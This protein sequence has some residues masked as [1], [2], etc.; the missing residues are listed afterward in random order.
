MRVKIDI[1]DPIAIFTGLR[2]E[3]APL[4][5]LS[6]FF[7]ERVAQTSLCALVF[8]A[9]FHRLRGA[10]KHPCRSPTPFPLEH[11]LMAFVRLLDHRMS[12][13]GKTNC[14]KAESVVGCRDR[15]PT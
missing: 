2:R 6:S 4:S 14:L 10:K 9:P 12:A 3:P 8:G 7:S 5:F 15:H 1:H 13:F 11:H